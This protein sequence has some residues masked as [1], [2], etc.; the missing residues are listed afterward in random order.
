MKI[1]IN[2]R[3]GGFNIS[4]AA[5]CRYAEIKG[6]TLYPEVG[7]CRMVT[8]WLVP[9]SER[10]NQDNFYSLSLEERH[11]SNARASGQSIS[12]HAFDRADPAL[13]QT[14]EELGDKANGS[15]AKLQIVEI[16]DDA[17]WEIS[18]YDGK[19][20]VAEKHRTWS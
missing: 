15:C 17:Q 12:N 20:H 4:D 5:M 19:E 2:V 16:P 8:Y 1:A 7:A 14:I 10:E 13:I 6:F 3:Y 11:T 18:E 9:A